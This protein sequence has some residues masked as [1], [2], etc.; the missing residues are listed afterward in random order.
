MTK[1]ILTMASGKTRCLLKV[2]T[3]ATMKK[4][5]Q[6][7]HK[8]FNSKQCTAENEELPLAAVIIIQQD[9]IPSIKKNMSYKHLIYS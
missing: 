4:I 1:W 8:N 5:Y 2:K 6:F 9:K 3:T 7:K